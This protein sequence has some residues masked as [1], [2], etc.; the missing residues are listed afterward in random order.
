M[1][2]EAFQGTWIWPLHL[3]S[4]TCDVF[5]KPTWID[6]NCFIDKY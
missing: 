1:D 4:V 6:L 2:A 3:M 5:G